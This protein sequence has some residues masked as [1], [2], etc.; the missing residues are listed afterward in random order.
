M[1][2]R[3]IKESICTSESIDALTWFEEV[4]FYRL[5]VRCDDY[6]RYDGRLKILQGS[7]F[8][9]K[10]VTLKQIDDALHKLSTVGMVKR[11]EVSGKPFLQLTTWE[12]HQSIRAKRSK[13]PAEDEGSG[14]RL[15]ANDFGCSRNPIQFESEYGSDAD[16]KRT[17]SAAAQTKDADPVSRMIRLFAENTAPN[18]LTPIAQA[19]IKSWCDRAGPELVGAA[20]QYVAKNQGAKSWG[21]IEK[22]LA[23]WFGR[24]LR[25]QSDVDKYLLEKQR[26]YAADKVKSNPAIRYSQRPV[27]DPDEGVD[28]LDADDKR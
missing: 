9:L 26:V 25:T 27:E 13:Y 10:D 5:I 12:N 20:I 16:A 7:L 23:E 2:N 28:W 4:L 17:Q 6:G 21:Y 1:P 14:I 15:H 11:Y 18:N 8:P 19:A 3:I 24:G 22:P